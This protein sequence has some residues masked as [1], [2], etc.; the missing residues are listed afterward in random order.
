MSKTPRDIPDADLA[1]LAGLFASYGFRRTSMD[2]LA[3]TMRVSRQTLYNRF[4]TKDAVL[5][6][7]VKCMTLAKLEA[8]RRELADDDR[9]V[10]EALHAAFM[11]WEGDGVD[12]LVSSQH[13]FELLDTAVD[14][15]NGEKDNPIN[16]FEAMIAEM[17]ITRVFAGDEP[18]ARDAMFVITTAAKGLQ[19]RAD[20]TAA[21]DAG[22]RRVIGVML[23]SDA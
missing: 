18:A 20:S 23:K 21:Y 4:G 9:P 16:A 6:W 15:L 7:V 17:L 13:G 1:N 11:R 14:M 12:V 5:S 10:A 2:D 22:M 8:A 3:R 19:F